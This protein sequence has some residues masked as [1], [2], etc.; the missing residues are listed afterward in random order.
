[1]TIQS[2]WRLPLSANTNKP[3]IYPL[4]PLNKAIS[5]ISRETLRLSTQTVGNN[6][7][8]FSHYY[9]NTEEGKEQCVLLTQHPA[10]NQLFLTEVSRHWHGEADQLAPV[11]IKQAPNVGVHEHFYTT[12]LA[13]P[14][15]PTFEKAT[16]DVVEHLQS[17]DLTRRT[18]TYV[19]ATQLH[20]NL[21]N[22]HPDT[23]ERYSISRF[24]NSFM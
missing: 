5:D 16:S 2:F 14:D 10:V 23:L 3:P 4:F 11:Y 7:R 22:T 17:I 12:V 20:T 9:Y 24:P 6:N 1:M 15:S 8:L 21:L 13:Y 18:N 19:V